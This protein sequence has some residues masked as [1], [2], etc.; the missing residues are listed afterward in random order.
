MTGAVAT[1]LEFTVNAKVILDQMKLLLSVSPSN[2]TGH[3]AMAN[4]LF[5]ARE[6]KLWATGMDGQLSVRRLLTADTVSAE[7]RGLIPAAKLSAVLKEM[8]DETVSITFDENDHAMIRGEYSKLRI[9]GED[10]GDFPEFE[11]ITKA[12]GVDFHPAVLASMINHVSFAASEE[13]GRFAFDGIHLLISKTV[14]R[15]TATDSRRLAT[16]VIKRPTG[17]KKTVQAVVPTKAMILIRKLLEGLEESEVLV[18]LTIGSFAMSLTTAKTFILVRLREGEYPP[19]DKVLEM[20]W[21]LKIKV[22]R[23]RLSKCLKKAS[24]ALGRDSRAVLFK[25]RKE[26]LEL[27]ARDAEVGESEVTLPT[28]YTGDEMMIGFSSDSILD[29]LKVL[30]KPSAFLNLGGSRGPLM[31]RENDVH[32]AKY[33]FIIMGMTMGGASE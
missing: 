1:C 8:G 24:L 11:K 10:P 20:E 3:L 5:E 31:C 16:G 17:V 18:D 13:P 30:E 7:G 6:G 12:V 21:P 9:P 27:T 29:M 32:G 22:G 28:D 23:E 19:M 15:M 33:K 2:P 26:E 25:F 14:V 4:V